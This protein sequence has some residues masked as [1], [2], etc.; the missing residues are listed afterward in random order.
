MGKHVG[1]ITYGI[2]D[3]KDTIKD[4]YCLK[5][6]SNIILGFHNAVI[7]QMITAFGVTERAGYY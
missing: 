2:R 4:I 3:R 5:Q 1:C 6:V 7:K